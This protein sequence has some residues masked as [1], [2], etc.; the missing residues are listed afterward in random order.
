MKKLL[1]IT[2]I[3]VC[4]ATLATADSI[5]LSGMSFDELI[6]LRNQLNEEI[7]G[8]PEW[9]EVTVPAGDWVVGQD[10][11]AGVYGIRNDGKNSVNLSVWKNAINDYSNHGLQYNELIKSGGEYGRIQLE[12]GWIVSIG[13]PLVFTPPI[14]LGF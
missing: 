10:I 4:M 2:M 11:P 13:Y 5:D 3:L 9:K 1:A 7:I 8:R 14:S 12:E 6:S